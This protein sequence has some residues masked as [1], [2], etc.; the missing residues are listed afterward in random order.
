MQSCYQI[1]KTVQML[2]PKF[3]TYNE[4]VTGMHEIQQQET[5][6]KIRKN[7]FFS[8]REIK[9]EILNSRLGNAK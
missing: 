6:E 2:Q 7:D 9:L 4:K 5:I 8:I 3:Y 1:S